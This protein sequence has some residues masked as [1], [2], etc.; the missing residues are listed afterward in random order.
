MTFNEVGKKPP[1]FVEATA[2]AHT[3][4]NSGLE[5]DTAEIVYNNFKSVRNTSIV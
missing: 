4:L 1:V 2:I 3:I 5:F